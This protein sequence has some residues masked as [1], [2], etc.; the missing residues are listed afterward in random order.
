[1]WVGKIDQVVLRKEGPLMIELKT[2]SHRPKRFKI[3]TA[4]ENL[5]ETHLDLGFGVG[6]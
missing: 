6:V 4:K 1:M 5:E 3:W 2:M